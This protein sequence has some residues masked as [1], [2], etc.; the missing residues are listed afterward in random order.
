MTALLVVLAWFAFFPSRWRLGLLYA[1]LAGIAYGGLRLAVGLRHMN[2]T[3]ADI[4]AW[5][6]EG[7]R[8]IEAATLLTLLAP[9]ALA[10]IVCWKRSPLVTRRLLVIVSAVYLPL[11]ALYAAYNEVRL[12]MPLFLILLAMLPRAK[13]PDH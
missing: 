1:G 8:A 9:L 5:N 13:R 6:T 11:W 2:Y 4:L 7:W 3:P 12:L 10:S